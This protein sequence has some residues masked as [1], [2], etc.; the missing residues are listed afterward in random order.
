MDGFTT[1][2]AHYGGNLQP[3]MSSAAFAST[4]STHLVG[5]LRAGLEYV[6]SSEHS[7]T[8]FFQVTVSLLPISESLDASRIDTG[9]NST[10]AEVAR[11][12]KV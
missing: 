4:H 3:A 8:R 6:I 9:S 12:E 11:E 5:T 2:T 10:M 7:L 1:D